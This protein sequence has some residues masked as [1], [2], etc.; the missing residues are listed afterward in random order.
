M[1]GVNAGK[2]LCV[3]KGRR[4]ELVLDRRKRVGYGKTYDL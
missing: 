3:A 1:L 4:Y 2:S